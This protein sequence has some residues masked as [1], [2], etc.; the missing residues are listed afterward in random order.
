[1]LAL[2][3]GGQFSRGFAR[4]AVQSLQ[5]HPA[6]VCQQMCLDSEISVFQ[7]LSFKATLCTGV[8]WLA[9][10]LP[11]GRQNQSHR[12]DVLIAKGWCGPGHIPEEPGGTGGCTR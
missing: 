2:G 7:G 5:H 1:M 12:T 3:K 6:H 10:T 8:Y 9:R 4:N 11:C